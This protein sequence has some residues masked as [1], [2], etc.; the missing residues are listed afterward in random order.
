MY[1]K[2]WYTPA[3]TSMTRWKMGPKSVEKKSEAMTITMWVVGIGLL[4]AAFCC[5]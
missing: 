2:N 1:N 3:P 4:I 5:A